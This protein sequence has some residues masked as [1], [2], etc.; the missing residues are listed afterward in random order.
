MTGY[1]HNFW[2]F[3]KKHYICNLTIFISNI[4]II[5]GLFAQLD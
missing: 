1:K 3:I 2:T 5:L 4:R